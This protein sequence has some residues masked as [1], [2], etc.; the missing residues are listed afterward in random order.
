MA[1]ELIKRLKSRRDKANDEKLQFQ[2]LLDEAYRYAIPFRR[3]LEHDSKGEKR[4]NQ[5]FDQTAIAAAFRGAGKLQ[6]DLAP[7]GDPLLTYEPGPL[8]RNARDREQLKRPLELIS[9]VC[10]SFFLTGEWDL[11]FHEMALDL[12]AGTGAMLM[13]AGDDPMRPLRFVSVPINE[14]VIAST[15][16]N[17][18]GFIDWATKWPARAIRE[19]FPNAQFGPK[20]KELEEKDPEKEVILHQTSV[21]EKQANRWVLYAW[22]EQDEACIHRSETRASIWLTP[23][24]YRVPGETYGRGPIMLAM[25]AIK[26]ANM[27]AKFMLQAAAIAM[28]GIYTAV[29]DGVFNPHNSP[30]EPGAFWKVMRNGGALGPSVAR[31]PDPRLDLG[32]LFLDKVR[33]GIQATMMDQ[34][35]PPDTAAVRSATEILERVKRLATNHMGAFGRLIQEVVVP[36]GKRSLEVAYR[37]RLIPA[38]PNIDQLLVSVKVV[39]PLA[40]ARE[41]ERIKRILSWLEIVLAIAP[42]EVDQIARRKKMLADMAPAFGVKSDDVV[43]TDEREALEEEQAQTQELATAA[44]VASEVAKAAPAA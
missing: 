35:L 43:T 42:N 16:Y 20:L 8:V 38:L 1:S 28:L 32:D 5:A 9:D 6:Q 3:G 17:D 36:A 34:E 2:P 18:I 22:D 29:D 41:Q 11:A 33:M 24:Y 7:V 21:W 15:P 30:L 44:A 25:P 13:P 37:R 39:S 10:G 23:R 12:L 26:V 27:G 19:E 14:V 31:F 40:M 4:V